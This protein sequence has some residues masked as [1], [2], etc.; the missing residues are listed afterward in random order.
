[1]NILVTGG[2]GYI[3]SHIIFNL[4]ELNN[5]NVD[6]IDNCKNSDETVFD[7][8]KQHS[9]VKKYKYNLTLY[10]YDL[11]NL[12]ELDI[13]FKNNKYDI[14]IHL[15]GY[16]SI[17]ESI[18]DSL[19][20]YNN[21]IMGTLNL[22]TVMNRYNC[23]NI[24]FSSSASVYGT[25]NKGVNE[26][27]K[28]GI[29]ITNPYSKSKYFIEEILN[30][31]Y[32]SYENWKIISLRY[33]NPIGAEST[34]QLGDYPKGKYTNLMPHITNVLQ[35]KK[36]YLEIYGN[37]YNTSDGTCIRDY[38]HID[39]LAD[40]HIKSI[41]YILN[42]TMNVT[43][44]IKAYNVGIGKGVSVLELIKMM[45]YVSNKI[46]LYK[47]VNRRIGDVSEIYADSS[48]IKT[49]LNWI[50]K[51][52]LLDMCLSHCNFLKKNNYI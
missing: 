44:F 1:M 2:L 6:I 24:I 17:T 48:L 19:A 38:I 31:M 33:Y 26:K 3:G 39:D 16:K 23:K 13:I 46:I 41:N 29:N 12:K 10:K 42:D 25:N 27:N 47:F 5:C 49:E 22:I 50:P 43:Q 14:V 45:E 15:A 51:Y 52:D 30:D 34:G 4:I 35:N 8:L 11:I 28:I 9:I 21:N 18:L 40:A 36:K 20:Y 32:T 37:D 7:V